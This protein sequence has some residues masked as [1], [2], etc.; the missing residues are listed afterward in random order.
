MREM[1]ETALGKYSMGVEY[2]FDVAMQL[3][4]QGGGQAV[5]VYTI[6]FTRRSPLLGEPPLFHLAQIATAY[7]ALEQ[8]DGLVKNG[9]ADL[10]GLYDQKRQVP[11]NP[12]PAALAN[13]SRHP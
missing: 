1:I 3:L 5:V 11:A 7:P 8:I 10:A 9:V 6:L 2:G 13:G 12:A 4:T